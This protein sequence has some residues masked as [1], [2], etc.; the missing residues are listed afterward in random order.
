MPAKQ[1]A[2]RPEMNGRPTTYKG[3]KMRSRLEADYARHLDQTGAEW[4]YEP[5][6]F[7][8][9]TGQWL[10]DFRSGRFLIEVKP[11]SLLKARGG[12]TDW[13]VIRRIDEILARVE[14][15]WASEPDAKVNV[16]FWTYGADVAPFK[17]VGSYS[18]PWLTVC[19]GIPFMCLWQGRAQRE[20]VDRGL[21]GSEVP[22]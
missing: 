5:V 17:I 16:V 12:E 4:D 8:D 22:R 15:A 10:P 14:I 6:C 7:A 18:S 13:G 19:E 1:A 20:I 2:A 11:A 3:I 9:E 21:G